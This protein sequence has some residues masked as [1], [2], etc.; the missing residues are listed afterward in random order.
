MKKR[1]PDE[2]AANAEYQRRYRQRQ[3]ELNRRSI[4]L[5]LTADESKQVKAF[6]AGLRSE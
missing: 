6:L 4:S 3:R 1:S 5:W 2:Q